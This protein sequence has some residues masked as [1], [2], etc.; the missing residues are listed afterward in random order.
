M[1]GADRA[2]ETETV[3]QDGGRIADEGQ[4]SDTSELSFVTEEE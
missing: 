4:T 3:V 2:K 1:A